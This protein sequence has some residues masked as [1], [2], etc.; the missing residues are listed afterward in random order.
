MKKIAI[1]LDSRII[2]DGRVRRTIESLSEFYQVDLFCIKGESNDSLLFSRNVEVFYY[3]INMS[4]IKNNLLMHK[5]FNNLKIIFDNLNKKYD[6]IYVNDYPLLSTGVALKNKFGGKLIYDSHEIYIETINQFFPKKGWKSIYGIPLIS[7]NKFIHSNIEKKLVAKA[8]IMITVCDSLKKY[9]EKKLAIDKII[10]VK[11]CPKYFD[12]KYKS[13]IIR[14]RLKLTKRKK[15]Y[16][17]KV[18]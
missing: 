14:E 12:F 17:I 8:N 16:F 3:S 4:W 10:V 7:I 13:N 15:Y 11:N 2:N 5:K 18:M 6:F 9:F 1:L